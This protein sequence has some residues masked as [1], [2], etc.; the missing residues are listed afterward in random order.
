ME[1]SPTSQTLSK[2]L[3]ILSHIIFIIPDAFLGVICSKT[4][5]TKEALRTRRNVVEL[6]KPSRAWRK[7]RFEEEGPEE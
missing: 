3:T 5:R 1:A 2:V 4:L 7:L 6:K